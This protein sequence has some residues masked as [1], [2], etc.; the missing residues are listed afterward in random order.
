MKGQDIGLLLK[1]HCLN[2]GSE[3]RNNIPEP[4][5]SWQDWAVPDT[6]PAGIPDV[7]IDSDPYSVRVLAHLT[8]ISKSQVSLAFNRC[9]AVGLLKKDRRSGIPVINQRAL[10]E[11]IVY[12]V[13]YAFPV[14]PGPVTRGITTS[15]VAPVFNTPLM[16]AG[17][18]MPVWPDAR[19]QSK[20]QS[21]EPLFKS[22]T[23]AIKQDPALYQLLALVDAIRIGQPREK[24]LAVS[25]LQKYLEYS[26]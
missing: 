2:L 17:E 24:N 10:C 1:L 14:F 12:G 8:G 9:L 6:T 15:M 23:T 4:A 13:R 21:V 7:Q 26:K 16:S 18:L 11:F 19:G 5:K 25:L 22:A 20:G 3:G